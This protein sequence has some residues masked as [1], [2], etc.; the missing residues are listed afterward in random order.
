M[1]QKN[2]NLFLGIFE[3]YFWF[4]ANL[5][6]QNILEKTGLNA[7]IMDYRLNKTPKNN[8]KID[9]NLT[10]LTCIKHAL[11]TSVDMK[12]S[13]S[14]YK[15]ILRS[16][17]RHF[18]FKK[19]KLYTVLT[20]FLPKTIWMIQNKNV[21]FVLCKNYKF[22]SHIYMYYLIFNLNISVL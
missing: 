14:C 5:K 13:F 15:A 8:L 16:N 1:P 12:R 20:I 22:I 17:L 11:I 9:Y 3:F 4:L 7:V 19:F 10:D 6:L 21:L 2:W 18:K